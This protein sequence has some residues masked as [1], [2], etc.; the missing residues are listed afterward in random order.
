MSQFNIRN[1]REISTEP[2]TKFTNSLAKK[3]FKFLNEQQQEKLENKEDIYSISDDSGSVIKYHNFTSTHSFDFL[4]QY[5]P[6]S[7]PDLDKMKLW[8]KGDNIGNTI[9]D[10]SGYSNHGTLH[11]DPMLIDGTPFDYGIHTGG[12]KSIAVRFNRPTSELVN[13]EYIAIPDATNLQISG[14]ATGMSYFLRFRIHSLANQG[15][16]N[17]T[18]LEKKDN[19][20]PTNGM[21]VKVTTDGKLIV[22]ITRSGTDYKQETATS[23]IATDTVYELW[24]TYAVSGN[25]IKVYL[26]NVDKSL[27]ASSDTPNYHAGSNLEFNI[28]RRGA[29]SQGYVYGDFWDFELFKEKV[30][31]ATEVGRHYTNKWTLADIPFGQVMISDYWAT[32]YT[33][34]IGFTTTG[35]TTTGYTAG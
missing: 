2:L 10:I 13:A 35:Y 21:I 25:T 24:I 12:T 32:Y 14:I 7:E 16:Q 29:G 30:V 9:N 33:P 15:S 5:F 3:F 11:G 6:P 28:F 31:S 23:T 34:G 19:S 26:N 20:T 1:I 22:I 8:I 18:L 27:S 17:R 4:T